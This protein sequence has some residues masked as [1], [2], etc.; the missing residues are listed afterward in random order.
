[1]V[2]TKKKATPKWKLYI[3]KSDSPC[4]SILTRGVNG[5]T[6]FP[7]TRAAAEQA[8]V[9]AERRA[10]VN[11]YYPVTNQERKLFNFE[12][13]MKEVP[14]SY[15][16]YG[17]I[18][19]LSESRSRRGGV[20]SIEVK[21]SD[22]FYADISIADL[23]EALKKTLVSEGMVFGTWGIKNKAGTPMLYLIGGVNHPDKQ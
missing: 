5:R 18:K 11:K 10:A 1:M 13:H 9:F 3:P 16:F 2:A 17:P 4:T 21:T 6:G 15:T 14:L 8:L 22:G 23:L 20:T 19:L 7:E 12:D